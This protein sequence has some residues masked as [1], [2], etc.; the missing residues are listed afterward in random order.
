VASSIWVLTIY[1]SFRQSP[2]VILVA[3]SGST[4]TQLKMFPMVTYCKAMAAIV[5]LTWINFETGSKL[6]EF[7]GIVVSVRASQ[8]SSKAPFSIRNWILNHY[9]SCHLRC[10]NSAPSHLPGHCCTYTLA[11]LWYASHQLCHPVHRH[12]WDMCLPAKPSTWILIPWLIERVIVCSCSSDISV[13]L[14]LLCF[15]ISFRLL[16]VG[17]TVLLLVC[18][19]VMLWSCWLLLHDAF[20]HGRFGVS[21]SRASHITGGS[22]GQADQHRKGWLGRP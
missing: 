2:V 1:C 9:F 15:W 21:S 7:S 14:L 11:F 16:Y 6:P 8:Y 22:V 17:C 20:E 5:F 3:I 4:H 10:P 13:V 18:C 19:R 12:I